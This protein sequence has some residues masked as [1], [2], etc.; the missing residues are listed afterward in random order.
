MGRLHLTQVNG[1]W[2]MTANVL[3]PFR[4]HTFIAGKW[5]NVTSFKER[6]ALLC[7]QLEGCGVFGQ[8]RLLSCVF[9]SPWHLEHNQRHRAISFDFWFFCCCICSCLS[10]PLC[11]LTVSLLITASVAGDFLWDAA[12]DWSLWGLQGFGGFSLFTLVLF[13]A[14]P[15]LLS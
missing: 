11:W 4:R 6:L 3:L 5:R 9:C 14:F 2:E 10:E 1:E 8:Y 13:L 12:I 15:C 7:A